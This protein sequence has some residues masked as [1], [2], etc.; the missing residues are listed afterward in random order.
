MKRLALV[1]AA[2]VLGTGCFHDDSPCRRTLTLAW[3]FR[4]ADGDV[5][6]CSSASATVPYVDVY[7]ND[8]PVG[9]FD[10]FAGGG[11][12][13][14]PRGSSL[15]T[16]EGVSVEV[17]ATER[18]IYRDE[19]TI[20]AGA[21]GDQAFAVRPGEGRVNIDYTA[22]SAPAC[23]NGT[24]YV[25]FSVRDD[26]LGLVATTVNAATAPT[27]FPY[28]ADVVFRLPVGPYT[29]EWMDIVSGGLSELGSCTTPTFTV[30]AGTTPGEQ[31]LVPA[32]PVSLQTSCP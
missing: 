29:V 31:Q 7:A 2:A 11:T 24:C 32:F 20:D 30:S 26:I 21:C 1:L 8:L 9:S 25:W 28:P 12:V 5:V 17:D 15:I 23:T 22:E 4:T 19:F 3:D 13:S 18:I 14:L 27:T 10:C 16:V 6:G